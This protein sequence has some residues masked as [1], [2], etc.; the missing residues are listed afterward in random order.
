MKLKNKFIKS[1]L[2]LALGLSVLAPTYQSMSY[3]SDTKVEEKKEAKEL[4]EVDVNEVVDGDTIKVRMP[5][6]NEETV[7]FVL[8][9]TPETKHPKK[10]EEYFG[11]EASE[12]TKKLIEENGNKV[13]LEKDTSERDKYDRLLRYV[14][15]K[16]YEGVVPTK[17]ELRENSLNGKLVYDGYARVSPFPPDTLYISEFKENEEI[18]RANGYGMWKDEE[19]ALSIDAGQPHDEDTAQVHI[20]STDE[21]LDKKYVADSGDGQIK[22]IKSE[23]GKKLYYLPHYNGYDDIKVDFNNGG[24]LYKTEREALEA[25]FTPFDTSEAYNTTEL[26]TIKPD[27]KEESDSKDKNEENKGESKEVDEKAKKE[28][29]FFAKDEK[30]KDIYAKLSDEQKEELRKIDANNDG[31]ITEEELMAQGIVKDQIKE[32]NYLYPFLHP[33]SI[34]NEN[35]EESKEDE[36]KEDKKVE[37]K[38]VEVVQKEDKEEVPKTKTVKADKPIDKPEEAKRVNSGKQT[39]SSVKGNPRLAAAGLTGIGMILMA[40]YDRFVDN[41]KEVKES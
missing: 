41:K 3:A 15:L 23:D 17:V 19:K 35:N 32:A 28:E 6:G 4:I 25:G 9:N 24:H 13:Y 12:Y 29:S 36:K 21:R 38:K 5:D 2:V 14:W 26:D 16:P 20:N 37:T 33:E 8:V 10:G 22:A 27:K 34:K 31:K 39:D 18:A 30:T 1:A 40:A 7:R 11:K